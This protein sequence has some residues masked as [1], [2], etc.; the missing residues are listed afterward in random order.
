MNPIVILSGIGILLGMILILF[1]VI[2]RKKLPLWSI[3]A[4]TLVGALIAL[5]GVLMAAGA[6]LVG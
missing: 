5:S 3:I 4:F 2:S 1:T 6:L